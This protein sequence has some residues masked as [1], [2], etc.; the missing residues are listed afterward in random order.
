MAKKMLDQHCAGCKAEWLHYPTIK[1]PS[2]EMDAGRFPLIAFIYHRYC[3]KCAQ[4]M[5]T[6]PTPDRKWWQFWRRKPTDIDRWRA[7]HNLNSLL[8]KDLENIYA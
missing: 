3:F 5:L 7:H 6:T 4:A 1:I 2:G 8:E